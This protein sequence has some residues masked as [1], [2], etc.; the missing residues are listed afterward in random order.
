METAM[1]NHELWKTT[2]Y[3]KSTSLAM[4]M[5]YGKLI[6]MENMRIGKSLLLNVK[7][8]KLLQN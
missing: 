4:E 8:M 6:S 5:N 7:P 3:G 2:N 1:E